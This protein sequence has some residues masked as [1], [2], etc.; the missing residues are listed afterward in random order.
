MDIPDGST[1]G[2]SLDQ[3]GE[4]Y[5]FINGKNMGKFDLKQN[6]T[7]SVYVAFQLFANI[8]QVS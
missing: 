6:I 4:L 5:L 1:I 3:L 2:L 7:Q 8:K